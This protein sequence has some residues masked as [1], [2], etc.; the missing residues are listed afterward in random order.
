MQREV[1]LIQKDKFAVDQR[2]RELIEKNQKL[3]K[4]I[5]GNKKSAGKYK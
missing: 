3:E 5:Y 4:F 1:D 2:H